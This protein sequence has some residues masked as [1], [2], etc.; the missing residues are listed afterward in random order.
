M[1][2]QFNL[3]LNQYKS[4]KGEPYTHTSM[5]GGSWNIP[6]DQMKTFYKLYSKTVSETELHMTEKHMLNH[7][8]I[9]IDFD[10]EFKKQYDPRKIDSDFINGVCVHITKILKKIFGPDY[11]YTCIVLQRPYQYQK[12][13]LWAD[14]LHIQYPY[15]SCD[16]IIQHALRKKFIDTYKLEIKCENTIDKIYDEAV[17]QR[18]NWCLYLS[19]KKDKKPYDMVN[20]YNS[21]IDWDSLNQIQK[22]KLLSIRNKKELIKPINREYIKLLTK[23]EKQIINIKPNIETHLTEKEILKQPYTQIDVEKLIPRLELLDLKKSNKY[24]RWFS[25]CHIIKNTG[26]SLRLFI[27]FSKK[28]KDYDFDECINKWNKNNANNDKKAK[29]NRLNTFC[30]ED[31][32][33]KYEK[34]IENEGGDIKKLLKELYEISGSSDNNIAKIFFHLYPDLFIYDS[35]AI[36]G[37]Q[38]EGTW[39]TYDEFG[40][41]HIC[42]GMQKAKILLSSELY[43]IVKNDFSERLNE[44]IEVVSNNENI[45]EKDQRKIIDAFK[46]KGEKI[47]LKIKN[48]VSKCHIIEQLKEFYDKKKIFEQLDEVNQY[49]IGFNNGVYD[50]EKR[51][52]RNGKPGELM[53]SSTGYD[54]KEPDKK[55]VDELKKIIKSIYPDKAERDYEMTV[56]SFCL[57]GIMHLQEFYLIIGNGGNGK[58]VMTLLITETMG[59]TYCTSISMEC[60]KNK[61]NISA[62]EKSQQLAGCKASRFTSVIECN[63]KEGEEFESNLVKSMSGGDEQNCKF[64]YKEQTRYIPKFN[65]YFITNDQIPIKVTDNS[66]PR[67]VRICPHRVSFVDSSEYDEKNKFMALA[68]SG[69]EE[70]LRKKVEYKH[71]FFSILLEYYFKFLDN[72]K[73]LTIPES[74]AKENINFKTINNPIGNFIND[75]LIITND[76]DDKIKITDIRKSLQGYDNSIRET[77]NNIKGYLSKKNIKVSTIKGYPTCTGVKF[78]NYDILKEKLNPD[79]IQQLV[80]LEYINDGSDKKSTDNSDKKITDN[81]DKKITDNSEKKSTYIS[82]KKSTYRSNKKSDSSSSNEN[83]LFDDTSED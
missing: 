20:I 10:F 28:L 29:L 44:K 39:L 34:M 9:V 27:E 14:G 52:F 45:T 50:L 76:A 13:E 80:Y 43:D 21:D 42:N 60:F 2:S 15:I 75:C 36:S 41:Y 49:L 64:L 51:E 67:R 16:Y 22:I 46:Q 54:Y 32:E 12:K 82:N 69:I 23:V 65:L 55:Y 6:D 63:M 48:T 31:N 70:K 74:L 4:S 78:K 72:D 7:G 79:C 17:I 3:F 83:M 61:G 71:A 58:G 25:I 59:G 53:Y 62:N 38:K 11:D 66:V 35:E 1:K 8:P 77:N 18:N 19:T 47:L 81:S 40:K 57:P 30:L 68:V 56:F 24:D 5:S 73:K 26:G 37:N 33:K